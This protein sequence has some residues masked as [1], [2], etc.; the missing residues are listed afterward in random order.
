MFGTIG[1]REDMAIEAPFGRSRLAVGYEKKD[2]VW[3]TIWGGGMLVLWLWDAVFLNEPAFVR[4]QTAFLNS[5]LTGLMVVLL[6]VL[7]GWVVGVWLHLLSRSKWKKLYTLAMLAVNLLRSVPQII[8]V[9]IGYVVLTILLHEEIIGSVF[10]QLL[11]VSGVIALAVV[12]EIV[13]TVQARI[14]YF[15]TLDFVDA[16]LCCGIGESR[17]LNIEILWKNSRSYLLHK[18]IAI[19]GVSIFLQSSI[20]FIISVGLSTDVSLSNLPLTLGSLLATLDSKQDILA[21]SNIFGNPGYLTQLF[22]GHLQGISVA[23]VIVFTLLCM[24][25]IANGFQRRLKLV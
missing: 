8:A 15:R 5:A 20:D 9:L 18:T 2:L 16:M 23:F 22:V 24:Y 14:E 7:F 6:S 13:D 10:I 12:L 21:I 4:L 19:F 25:N 1:R 17:I 11:W 3:L